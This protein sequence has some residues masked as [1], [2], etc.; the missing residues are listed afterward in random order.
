MYDNPPLHSSACGRPCR[1]GP[2]TFRQ[3]LQVVVSEVT[4]EHSEPAGGG[5]DR[6]CGVGA[7]GRWRDDGEKGGR[8]TEG[9][10][11]PC[12]GGSGLLA[13]LLALL[14]SAAAAA[15]AAAEPLPLLVLAPVLPAFAFAP[16][17][18]VVFLV[19]FLRFLLLRLLR[20]LVWKPAPGVKDAVH[21]CGGAASS[22][23][24]VR[25]DN[26]LPRAPLLRR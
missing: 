24:E 15:V 1:P 10:G 26:G 13:L 3:H 20:L 25:P 21:G 5:V 8:A 17:L 4:L 2:R 12:R 16:A 22:G 6:S 14:L 19:D 23:D 18:L 7:S 9:P 11:G